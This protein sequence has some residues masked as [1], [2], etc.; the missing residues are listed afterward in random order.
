[1][2]DASILPLRV[3]SA[4]ANQRSRATNDAQRHP[5]DGRNVTRVRCA[6]RHLVAVE[7]IGEDEIAR[8][9][10]RR[11]GER[12]DHREIAAL[13]E[14]RAVRGRGELTLEPK[15]RAGSGMVGRNRFEAAAD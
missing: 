1:M 4:Y 15:P 11:R 14:A 13:V 12:R 5:R 7:A 6:C 3:T 2:R 8:A 10:E 9:A